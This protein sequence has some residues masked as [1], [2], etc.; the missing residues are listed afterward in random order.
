MLAQNLT[1]HLH[2][3]LSAYDFSTLLT[4]L[5]SQPVPGA[6]GQFAQADVIAAAATAGV[7]NFQTI[8][9]RPPAIGQHWPSQGGTYAGTLRGIDGE[10]DCALIIAQAVSGETTCAWGPRDTDIGT[11]SDI[12]GRA[13]TMLLAGLAKTYPAARWA[14]RLR[15]D[16]HEDWYLPALPALRELQLVA[17]NVP[18]AM[19]PASHYWTS[20]G[21]FDNSAWAQHY[22]FG[23]SST[24]QKNT[25]LRARVVRR[26]PL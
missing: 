18:E 19:D 20:T 2:Q 5:D 6:I 12:D 9:T 8:N 17:A 1:L 3:P 10:A 26:V 25:Q 13:N 24:V 22:E 4:T 15:L 7:R 11:T 21:F 14:L 23:T 16:G